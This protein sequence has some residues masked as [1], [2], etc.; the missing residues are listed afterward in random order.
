VGELLLD[1][2]ALS[3]V[4][5]ASFGHREPRCELIRVERNNVVRPR[6][7]SIDLFRA[8]VGSDEHNDRVPAG[9]TGAQPA[10]KIEGRPVRLPSNKHE[11]IEVDVPLAKG[12][13]RVVERGDIVA[14][15][16]E[17]PR[18]HSAS[19]DIWLQY[20]YGHNGPCTN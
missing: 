4:R 16:V 14:T 13:H 19:R 10:A 9:R 15:Q 2:A 3:R 1:F 8:Q 17:H 12:D 5:H 7:K 20:E 6:G 11:W 18:D